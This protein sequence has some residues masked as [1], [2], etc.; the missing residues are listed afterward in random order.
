MIF[1]E[2]HS[3]N[4]F[5]WLLSQRRVITKNMAWNVNQKY[6]GSNV[7]LCHLCGVYCANI[8]IKVIRNGFWRMLNECH[9][10]AII[11]FAQ[12]EQ[13]FSNISFSNVPNKVLFLFFASRYNCYWFITNKFFIPIF[14]KLSV[15]NGYNDSFF[16]SFILSSISN[17][18]LFHFHSMKNKSQKLVSLILEYNQDFLR[19][20][21]E[22]NVETK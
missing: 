20:I 4:Y 1:D 18:C 16:F 7:C 12:T 13:Y 17:L 9:K 8:R 11:F 15:V 19:A 22:K 14:R 3:K 21:A 2:T 10:T 5:G 6:I